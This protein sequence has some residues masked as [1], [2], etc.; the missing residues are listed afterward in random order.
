VTIAIPTGPA[1][2]IAVLLAPGRKRRYHRQQGRDRPHREPAASGRGHDAGEVGG[3]EGDEPLRGRPHPH[4]AQAP[5]PRVQRH[6][7]Q[8]ERESVQRMRRVNDGHRLGAGVL[9]NRGSVSLAS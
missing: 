7:P 9:F 6:T 1:C 8:P 3:E 5:V 2:R 4:G